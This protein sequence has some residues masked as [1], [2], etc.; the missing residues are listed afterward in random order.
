[1]PGPLEGVRILDLSHTLAG[2]FA[3]MVLAD[4]GADV[5]KVEPPGG[6]ETRHWAPHVSGVSAYYLS[7]NRGKRSI[8][9]DLK[10]DEGREI[11]YR[12]ARRSHVVIENY[13]PGV[14]EKLRVAPDDLFKVNPG[15]VYLSIKG[16]RPG[17]GYED[18][19]AYDILVQGMSG[20]MASTGEEERPPVRVSFA[21]FDIITGLLASTYILAGLNTSERPLYIE[22][23]LY[24]AAI[25]A[26]S[27]IP[28]IYLITGSKPRRMGSG[29]PSIVPYQAFQTGDGKWMI[30]AA[31]NDRLWAR[32][33]K[34]IGRGDLARDP[35]FRTNPDRVRNRGQ[36][37]PLLEEIFKTRPRREW[38]EI[39]RSHGVPAAPVYDVDEVFKDPYT[40]WNVYEAPHPVLGGVKQLREPATIN[41]VTPVAES[42]PPVLGEHTVEVLKW[43]G[44]TEEEVEDLARKGVVQAWRS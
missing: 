28:M 17:S 35:R 37:I 38:I 3:T 22:T 8:V 36:L 24:D 42:H 26:M 5:V 6:D 2:P 39:L 34:A 7:V 32:L 44:Y 16:F 40:G 4:L 15:L 43:L 18:L 21:L 10:R 27:Y 25:F 23:Y 19:P 31:A 9:V 41:G 30:I 11:V 29:H 20:L 1:M 13:R 14:R 12:L 33:C